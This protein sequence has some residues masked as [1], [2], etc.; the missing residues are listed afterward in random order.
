[1]LIYTYLSETSRITGLFQK[2]SELATCLPISDNV[3]SCFLITDSQEISR[4]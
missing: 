2:Q 4:E 3:L 1:M